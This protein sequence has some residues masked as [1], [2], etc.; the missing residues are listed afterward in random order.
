MKDVENKNSLRE[1]VWRTELTP[2]QWSE[3]VRLNEAEAADLRV[4][5]ALTS[6]LNRLPQA[7]VPSNFTNR[8]LQAVEL[9]RAAASRRKSPASIVFRWLPRFALGCA[10]VAL[11]FVGHRQVETRRTAEMARSVAIVPAP[12]LPADILQDFDAIQVMSQTPS[13][14][15]QLLALME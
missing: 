1:Q 6:A 4:E 8:V 5:S 9:E 10:V 12:S 3:A 11:A 2:G 15:V 13:A 14:D 7:P